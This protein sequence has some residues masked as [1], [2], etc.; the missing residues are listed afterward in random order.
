MNLLHE[1]L[2][3]LGYSFQPEQ[4]IWARSE[5]LP[6]DYSDGDD[7]ENRLHRIISESTD[8]SIFSRQLHTACVDWPTTY[9]LSSARANLLRPLEHLLDG[10]VLE[11]GAGCGAITRYLGEA[12]ARVIAVEGSSRRAAI[13]AQ[14][15]RDLPNV[16]VIND[17]FERFKPE[18]K[19]DVITLI[20]VLEYAGKFND[21]ANPVRSMLDAVRALLKP[22]GVLIIAI[23]NQLGLKYLAGAPE[24]HLGAPRVGIQGLYKHPGVETFGHLELRQRL[25][26]SGFEHI[27]TALPFPD[28]KLPASIVLP[29][30]YS[31]E[32]SFDV[33]AL[34]AQVSPRDPQISSEYLNFSLECTWREVGKNGLL[35]DLSNSFLIAASNRPNASEPLFEADLLACHYSSNRQPAYC[36][37][38]EFRKSSQGRIQ[39]NQ[40]PLIAGVQVEESSERFRHHRLDERFFSGEA[41]STGLIRTLQTP[42][43]TTKGLA[44]LLADYISVVVSYAGLPTSGPH[45]LSTPLPGS[46]LDLVPQ[47]I[48]ENEDKTQVIDLEWEYAE[49]ISLGYLVFRAITTLLRMVSSLAVP[50]ELRWLQQGRLFED[51]YAHLGAD[52]GQ[53]DY[54]RFAEMEAEFMSFVSACPCPAIPYDDWHKHTLP[55]F[56]DVSRRETSSLVSHI[57]QVE[58][59][60]NT[61]IAQ[62]KWLEGEK[63]RLHQKVDNT[64]AEMAELENELQ[65]LSE[66]VTHLSEQASENQRLR[67][68]LSETDAELSKIR[69]SRI[70]RLKTHLFKE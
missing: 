70:W 37:L 64:L 23:E 67:Q 36:K 14:R 52:F 8:V 51:L 4:H 20:G 6:F 60:A 16:T 2:Q 56:L 26:E 32:S 55:T 29:S 1:T 41:L 5:P 45:D 47:N 15:T 22:D 40:R 27:E 57:Q 46:L 39:V 61:Y 48:L 66:E 62:V 11:I 44:R 34:A 33:S 25:V 21:A 12:G 63:Q 49:D 19:F 59:L 43:W 38:V 35:A 54:E 28:Y 13:A 31:A 53:A 65:K 7:T 24:D 10:D 68:K 3:S 58:E 69:S 18:Q 17:Q 9:H 50:C 30:G 42:S